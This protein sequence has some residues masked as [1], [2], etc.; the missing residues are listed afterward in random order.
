MASVDALADMLWV[1]YCWSKPMMHAHGFPTK[2]SMMSSEHH[3]VMWQCKWLCMTSSE[4]HMM[5]QWCGW[6]ED[7]RGIKG[8]ECKGWSSFLHIHFQIIQVQ[9][10]YGSCHT[11]VGYLSASRHWVCQEY[12]TKWKCLL[13]LLFSMMVHYLPIELCFYKTYLLGWMSGEW[14]PTWKDWSTR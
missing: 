2:K 1:M 5:S 4:H 11:V 13:S 6:H 7:K 9:K 14:S 3:M 12:S 10:G 8:Y